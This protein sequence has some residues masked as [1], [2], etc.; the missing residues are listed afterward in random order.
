MI[1]ILKAIKYNVE[2]A[3]QKCVWHNGFDESGIK[4]D[5]EIV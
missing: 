1:D 5:Y 4:L 2:F 3:A